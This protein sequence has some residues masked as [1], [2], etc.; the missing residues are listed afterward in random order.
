MD[1]DTL[2]SLMNLESKLNASV[3]ELKA[4]IQRSHAELDAK[5]DRLYAKLD[6]KIDRRS[7]GLETRMERTE[8][9]RWGVTRHARKRRTQ[10]GGY[11]GAERIQAPRMT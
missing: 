10:R 7:G 8:L 11:R 4:D 3:R 2:R 9:I 6:V 5:I 1:E